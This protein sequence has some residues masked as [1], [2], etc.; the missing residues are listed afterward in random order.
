MHRNSLSRWRPKKKLTCNLPP[1]SY[2]PLV[3]IYPTRGSLPSFQFQSSDS[4][5]SYLRSKS[6]LCNYARGFVRS[7]SLDNLVMLEAVFPESSFLLSRSICVQMDKTEV[8]GDLAGKS[9]AAAVTLWKLSLVRHG[10][11]LMS[12]CKRVVCSQS[13]VL[14]VLLCPRTLTTVG[15]TESLQTLPEVVAAKASALRGCLRQPS[16]WSHCS[17]WMGQLP[18]FPERSDCFICMKAGL[19]SW[20][21]LFR[22]LHPQLLPQMW[23]SNSH[24][25]FLIQHTSGVST[26]LTEPCLPEAY[27]CGWPAP[28]G[29]HWLSHLIGSCGRASSSETWRNV[30]LR[31]SEEAL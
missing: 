5:G 18:D 16:S 23:E 12:T 13:S 19:W 8:A 27:T 20:Q 17:G 25:K 3:K 14:C 9:E 29:L 31:E 6:M 21:P 11:S 28:G 24:R 7:C 26:S 22:L 30:R 2:F 10:K 4:F 1:I 15:L